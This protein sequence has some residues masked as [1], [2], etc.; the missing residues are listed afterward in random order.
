[1]EY[2]VAGA[3]QHARLPASAPLGLTWY[4]CR[5][6][7][8]PSRE[9]RSNGS[10]AHRLGEQSGSVVTLSLLAKETTASARWVQSEPPLLRLSVCNNRAPRPLN[11]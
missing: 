10:H 11:L 9:T 6:E 3:C 7:A 4:L 1:M 5:Y 8:S 2:T